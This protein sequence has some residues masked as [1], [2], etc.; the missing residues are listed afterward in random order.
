MTGR[1]RGVPRCGGRRVRLL[2]PAVVLAA[3][4]T[5]TGCVGTRGDFSSDVSRIGVSAS[6]SL[7]GQRQ[8]ADHD[9]YLGSYRADYRSFTG[10]EWPFGGTFRAHGERRVVGILQVDA[11]RGAV[12]VSVGGERHRLAVGGGRFDE[13]VDIPASSF[14]VGVEG[15]GLRGR[16]ELSVR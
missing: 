10:G 14:Y 16:L 3:A 5:L 4:L 1:R 9:S 13:R 11:G 7:I 6:S 12:V 2:L 8:L 15:D